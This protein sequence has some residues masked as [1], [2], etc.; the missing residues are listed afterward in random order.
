MSGLLPEVIRE[1]VEG[2]SLY[3]ASTSFGVVALAV[4]VIMLIESEALRVAKPRSTTASA[5]SAV[6]VPLL[7]AVMLTIAAR[8]AALL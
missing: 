4:L 2:K 1:A 3:S 5:L 8:V 7:I 6:T